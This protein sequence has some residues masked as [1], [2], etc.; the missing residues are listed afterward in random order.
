MLELHGVL[1]NITTVKKPDTIAYQACTQPDNVKLPKSR[2]TWHKSQQTYKSAEVVLGPK[3]A[4]SELAN[5]CTRINL[6]GYIW[7]KIALQVIWEK[8]QQKQ[9]RYFGKLI[10][11]SNRYQ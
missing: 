6:L 11:D 4:R 3:F 1:A 2:D 5:R 9:K 8:C 10:F 7:Y